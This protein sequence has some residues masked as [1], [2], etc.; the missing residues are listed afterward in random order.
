[1][2][3]IASLAP[4]GWLE[5]KELSDGVS[6]DGLSDD[7]SLLEERDTLETIRDSLTATNPD[8]I[9]GLLGRPSLGSDGLPSPRT[10]SRRRE[11]LGERKGSKTRL[12]PT[13]P[14]AVPAPTCAPASTKN[15]WRG[16]ALFAMAMACAALSLQRSPELVEYGPSRRLQTSFGERVDEAADGATSRRLQNSN[17]FCAARDGWE[18]FVGTARAGEAFGGEVCLLAS[19]ST[20]SSTLYGS[21]AAYSPPMRVRAEFLAADDLTRQLGLVFGV[22]AWPDAANL[23]ATGY[24][25]VLE[26]KVTRWSSKS[27]LVLRRANADYDKNPDWINFKRSR[28]FDSEPN[29]WYEATAAIDDTSAAIAGKVGADVSCEVRDD[30]GAVVAS[31]RKEDR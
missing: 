14:A 23:P 24:A 20:E 25:C 27:R 13:P 8:E 18:A 2:A 10:P 19:T 6:D 16:F 21:H 29:A 5:R 3:S 7:E 17:Q 11:F 31:V 22:P 15:L 26:H 28:W 4:D 9:D 1:M 12:S 30:G